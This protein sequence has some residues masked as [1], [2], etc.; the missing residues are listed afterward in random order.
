MEILLEQCAQ[1]TDSLSIQR[2]RTAWVATALQESLTALLFIGRGY[3][4]QHFVSVKQAGHEQS[5]GADCFVGS[6]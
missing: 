3:A 2:G 4:Y 6:A 5:T 1:I